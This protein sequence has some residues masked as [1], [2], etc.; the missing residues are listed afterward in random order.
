M[1]KDTNFIAIYDI[2]G[3]PQGTD[4]NILVEF[5]LGNPPSTVDLT[6]FTGVLQVRRNYDSP[7]LL[8]LTSTDG[9]ILFDNIAP[10][11]S[12]MFPHAK[13]E[14]MTVYEDMIYDLKITSGTG[15]ITRVM[16]GCFSLN[17]EVTR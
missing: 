1:A 15:I 16:Q 10:N 4:F 3:L 13:T 6:G 2:L 11:I 9:E 7:V 5:Q 14:T 12:I 8:E 17:R